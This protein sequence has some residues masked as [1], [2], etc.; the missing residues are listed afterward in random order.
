MITDF[1][2]HLEHIHL[3]LL[4]YRVHPI[5]ADNL[6][7]VARVL[8]VVAFDVFPQLLYHLGPRQLDTVSIASNSVKQSNIPDSLQPTRQADG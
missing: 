7:L 4:E 1:L 5:V 2:V 6:S 3:G 8:Q